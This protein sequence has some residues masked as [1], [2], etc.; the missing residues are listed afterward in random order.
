MELYFF[1]NVSNYNELKE[2][3][4]KAYKRNSVNKR[5]ANIVKTINLKEENTNH[6][7]EKIN[8]DNQYVIENVE[9]MKIKDGVWNCIELVAEDKAMIVMADGYPYAKFVALKSGN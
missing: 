9:L 4:E 8:S 6:Y 5:K 7:F 2:K 1:R 3:T